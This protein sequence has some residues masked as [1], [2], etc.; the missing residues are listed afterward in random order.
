MRSDLGSSDLSLSGLR[1]HIHNEPHGVLHHG[2][3][4]LVARVRVD[5][6]LDADVSALVP[7]GRGALEEGQERLRLDVGHQLVLAARQDLELLAADA[8]VQERPQPRL[9]GLR[10]RGAGDVAGA[11]QD[12]LGVVLGNGA[13]ERGREVAAAQ[14]R[15]AGVGGREG[16]QFGLAGAV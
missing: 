3:A 9:L 6:V 11:E 1:D 10:G 4:E 12:P 14:E 15:G 8:R 2:R 5:I 7:R 16:R 13:D